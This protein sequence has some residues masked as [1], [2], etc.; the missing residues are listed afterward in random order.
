M[1]NVKHLLKV[2]AAWTSI[3]YV[4]CYVGVAMMP[5]IRP[6]FMMYAFH[7]TMPMGQNVMTGTTFV[8]GLVIWNV[9]ALFAVWLF[10]ALFN[11]IKK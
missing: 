5:G 6:G 2:T 4:I 8:S 9:A 3:I 1:I 11:G 10:T 7:N